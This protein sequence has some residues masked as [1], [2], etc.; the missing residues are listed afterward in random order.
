MK[1]LLCFFL[2]LSPAL[3]ENRI[4][5]YCWTGNANFTFSG[6]GGQGLLKWG[7]QNFM[8]ATSGNKDNLSWIKSVRPDSTFVIMI[9]FTNWTGY[10]ITQFNDGR[11]AES[12]Y[13]CKDLQ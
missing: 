3:A 7:D 13:A 5:I 2:M 11:R 9:D 10:G 4:T 6:Y 8:P 12:Y 1:W